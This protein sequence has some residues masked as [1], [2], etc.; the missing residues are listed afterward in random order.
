MH[1]HQILLRH[2]QHDTA[3]DYRFPSDLVGNFNVVWSAEPGIDL[4]SRAAE[5]VRATAEAGT[6]LSVPPSRNYPGAEQAAKNARGVPGAHT[7]SGAISNLTV[8]TGTKYI[9]LVA[10]ESSATEIH[11]VGCEYEFGLLRGIDDPRAG[12]YV[13]GLGFSVDATRRPA[14]TDPREDTVTDRYENAVDRAPRYDA[15]APWNVIHRSV[16][17]DPRLQVCLRKGRE[18]ARS[19]PAYAEQ[20]ISDQTLTVSADPLR[21]ELFPILPQ[22]PPWPAP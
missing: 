1:R 22:N 3:A 20:Q 17:S 15:F 2:H 9:H 21:P 6:I 19:H 7:F 11:A 5:V 4:L 13:G 12:G 14:S 10:L 8:K 18:I 16:H